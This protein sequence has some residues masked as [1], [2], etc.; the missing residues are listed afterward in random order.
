MLLK[1]GSKGED[2]KKLQN[3]LGV[4]ADGDFGANTE[5]AVK[6]WQNAHGLDIDGIVGNKTWEKMLN[7]TKSDDIDWIIKAFIPAHITKSVGR[8]IKYLVIHYTAGGNSNPGAAMTNRNVFLKRDASAD[9]CVDDNTIVQ[10][11]PDI[12]NY[13]C[14][15]VGDGKGKYGI[16]NKDCVNI[17]ICSNIKSGTS[18]HEPNH[19]GWYFTEAALN[20]TVKLAK[21][22]MKTYNIPYDRVIRHYDATRKCCPGLVGWNDGS[23]YNPDGTPAKKKNTSEKWLEFKK[24]LA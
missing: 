19:L 20:N 13:Y 15:A 5:K 9:F 21:Y 12:R 23:L 10:V 16:Y 24:R 22:L 11:N 4:A 1:K 7:A 6:E 8:K 18:T 3:I 14:W 2:V 17:E